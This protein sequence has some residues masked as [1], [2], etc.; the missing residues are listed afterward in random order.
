[1][2]NIKELTE[3]EAIEILTFVYPKYDKSDFMSIKH[4]PT[5]TEDGMQQITFGG[6]S[7]IGIEYHNGQDRCILHFDNTKVVLW[8]YKN[9]FDITDLLETNAYMSEMEN[10][11][12]NAMFE[13]MWLAKGE[14]GFK[15]EVRHRWTLDYVK[16]KCTDIYDKYFIKDYE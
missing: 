5:I 2:K 6:R 4:E 9:G 14:E 11:F 10:D 16:K 7:I 12:S 3:Q 15:P 1:M 8:L 13:V